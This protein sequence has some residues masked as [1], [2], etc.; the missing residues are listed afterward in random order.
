MADAWAMKRL[1]A[2]LHA[3]LLERSLQ[4][5]GPP[6]CATVSRELGELRATLCALTSTLE[7]RLGAPG[8]PRASA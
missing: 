2:R 3:R 5:L 4:S 1:A 7:A 6:A 8:G